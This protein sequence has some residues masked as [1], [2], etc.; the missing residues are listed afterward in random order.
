MRCADEQS[1]G[2]DPALGQEQIAAG[3]NKGDEQQLFQVH[4]W[5]LWLW[6]T[7]DHVS[8]PIISESLWN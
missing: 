8:S 1:T 5:S 6:C 4:L 7:Y 2:T 3:L